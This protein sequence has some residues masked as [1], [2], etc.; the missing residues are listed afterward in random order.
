MI[1]ICEYTRKT[2]NLYLQGK[3]NFIDAFQT[4]LP[5]VEAKFNCS[6]KVLQADDG[7]EFIST[8][9]KSFCKKR[10]IVIRYAALYIHKKN[11]LAK[12]R[13]KTIFTIKNLMLIDSS[14]PNGFWVE[15]META[16]Y[17]CNKLLTRSKNHRKIISEEAC[18][19]EYQDL[20]HIWIFKSLALSNISAEKRTKSDYQKVW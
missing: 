2:W 9:L 20:Q 5:Q 13:W 6:I 3:N 18:T 15:A 4:W 8:K 17:L 7:R 19:G 12:R 16:N 1:L 10:G 11:G 14:L